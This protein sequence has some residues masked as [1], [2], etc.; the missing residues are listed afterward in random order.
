M[1]RYS[2]YI[3]LFLSASCFFVQTASAENS[4]IQVVTEEWKPY[5]YEEDG[6]IRGSST[7]V[8]KEIMDRSGLEY[9]INVFPWARA[10]M[11]AV[12]NKNTLIY[13]IV[14][15]PERD[16]KFIWVAPVA[17]TDMSYFYKLSTRKDIVINSL[18]DAKQYNIGTSRGGFLHQ[19]LA[20]HNF[21]TITPTNHIKLSLKQLIGS[22][23]DL[24][25]SESQSIAFDMQEIAQPIDQIEKAFL[26]Q[27]HHA[28]LAF[29]NNASNEIV[30]KVKDAYSLLFKERNMPTVD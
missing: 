5:S 26:V 19:F 8:V 11:M 22:R 4:I 17:M 27:S 24:V 18:E 13:P 10:Y 28:Y 20:K 16:S 30:Q 29:G 2:R 14:R 7:K 25:L 15:T 21:P 6:E 9:Q 1:S 23:V 3:I 12:R